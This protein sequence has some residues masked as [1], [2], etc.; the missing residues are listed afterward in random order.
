MVRTARSL[1]VASGVVLVVAMGLVFWR[2]LIEF[3]DPFATWRED[4]DILLRQTDWGSTW[5]KAAGASLAVPFLFLAA[6]TRRGPG[7]RTAIWGMVTLVVVALCSFPSLTGHAS[8]MEELRRTAMAADTLHVL[9]AGLWMGGLA[10]LLATEGSA[11]RASGASVLGELVPR[12]SPIALAS[13]AVL[14]ATGT[15]A[16]WLHIEQPGL[17]ISSTY[18][19]L[20]LTKVAFVSLVLGLGALNWRR[21]TPRLGS[22]AGNAALRRA[23]TVELLLAHVVIVVTALLVRTSPLHDWSWS[24][25]GH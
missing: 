11:M 13:V 24:N 23:A 18:G 5:I 19:R 3:R 1:G 8:G 17:L 16:S 12:F 25:I 10:V 14:I 21:L 7:F 4:A 9:A 20:L 22:D 6:A 2:Q 15:F